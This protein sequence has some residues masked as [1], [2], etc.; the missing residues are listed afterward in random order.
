MPTPR[1]SDTHSA[2]SAAMTEWL[3]SGVWPTTP[4]GQ[5]APGYL[6]AFLLQDEG[7]RALWREHQTMLLAEWRRRGGLGKPW[8]QTFSENPRASLPWG[9]RK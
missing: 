7:T 4:D 2:L 3:L 6:E 5:R 9:V 8:G 1:P